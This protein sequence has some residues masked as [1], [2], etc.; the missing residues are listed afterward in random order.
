MRKYLFYN[1]DYHSTGFSKEQ[2]A[3]NLSLPFVLKMF[4][5]RE[6]INMLQ[7]NRIIK[8]ETAY[9]VED[10]AASRILSEFK[11]HNPIVNV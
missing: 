6:S 5:G 2:S 1:L 8:R 10:T 9:F 7:R 3:Y 4:M 11:A